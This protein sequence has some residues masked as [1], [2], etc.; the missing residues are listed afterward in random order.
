MRSSCGEFLRL[1]AVGT[2]ALLAGLGVAACGG[3]SK[4]ANRSTTEQTPTLT[5]PTT[6]P[7]VVP[8]K[9]PKPLKP[10]RPSSPPRA[11]AGGSANPAGA[12]NEIAELRR[13]LYKG[14][15][16]FNAPQA[17]HRDESAEIALFVGI[18]NHAATMKAAL[19]G[20][21]AQKHSATVQIS[22]RMQA[23]L[24]GIGFDI[25]P[26]SAETQPVG[27]LNMTQWRW[28]VSPTQTGKLHLHLTLNALLK[29]GGETQAITLRTFDRTI[30]INV[31]FD[32]RVSSFFGDNWQWLFTTL[33]LPIG[34]SLWRV[35]RHRRAGEAAPE[36]PKASSQP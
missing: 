11:H 18:G 2:A 22:D 17:L 13:Q 6:T 16:A 19:P 3:G 15:V 12:A 29:N 8:H 31:T 1:G 21:L 10:P 20:P 4:S 32:Q 5:A 28:Q 35:L 7:R 25:Q 34:V 26:E 23:K 33:L 14:S 24:T 9:K 27:V 36:G 30:P